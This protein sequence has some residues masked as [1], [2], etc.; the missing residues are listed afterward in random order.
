MAQIDSKGRELDMRDP[1][2]YE[3]HKDL[4]SITIAEYCKRYAPGEVPLAVADRCARAWLGATVDEM[5]ALFF[6]DYVRSGRGFA[7]LRSDKKDGGQYLRLRA[8]NSRPAQTNAP[9]L[10]SGPRALDVLV[11]RADLTLQGTQSFSKSL[12]ATLPP[13]TILLSH[14]VSSISQSINGHCTVSSATRSFSIQCRKVIVSTPTPLYRHIF[15]DPILPSYKTD[16]TSHT[17]LGYYAKTLLIYSWPWWR[18]L[19]LS[20][21]SNSVVGPVGFTRDTC[22][23]D[24][25]QYSLTCFIVASLGRTWSRLSA[26]ER[27]GQVLEQ[28]ATMFGAAAPGGAESVPKPVQILEQEWVKEEW[29]EGAPNPVMALGALSEGGLVRITEPFM[30][31]HFVGTETADVWRGYMDGAVRSGERGAIEVIDA[32]G[33]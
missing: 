21:V 14:P 5:S 9:G 31:V 29:I 2:N 25:H 32:L 7:V 4:D 12:A 8:G 19:N 6:I 3:K 33:H 20:G 10:K 16:I 24:D 22:S 17:A 30:N 15:F 23:K 13:D 18:D 1:K 27:Q 28:I 26:T 11:P